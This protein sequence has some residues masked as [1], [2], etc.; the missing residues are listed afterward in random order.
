MKTLSI[1][2]CG[3]AL[4]RDRSPER[5]TVKKAEPTGRSML[6]DPDASH[7]LGAAKRTIVPFV[8]H[9]RETNS[10]SVCSSRVDAI[11]TRVEAFIE[12]MIVAAGVAGVVAG[13]ITLLS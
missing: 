10:V 2:A 1:T 9:F 3:A 11:R 12:L 4:V 7:C 5:R 13:F 6:T 8:S